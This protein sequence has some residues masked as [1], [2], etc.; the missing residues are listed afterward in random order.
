MLRV[1][2]ALRVMWQARRTSLYV[3]LCAA[4]LTGCGQDVTPPP[5]PELG[6]LFS[7]DEATRSE[8]QRALE[9]LEARATDVNAWVDLARL[10]DRHELYGAALATWEGAAAL[11]PGA[12]EWKVRAGAAAVRARDFGRAE[13]WLQAS[14]DAAPTERGAWRR[15][16]EL[17]LEQGDADGARR[18]FERVQALAPKAHD[19][20]AGLALAA[21]LAEDAPSALAHARAA[22]TLAPDDP[23]LRHVYGSALRLAGR[24]EEALPHLE[25]GLG[26]SP[27]WTDET[28]QGDGAV[29]E[30]ALVERADALAADAKLREAAELYRRVIELRPGDAKVRTRLALTLAQ[31]GQV[32]AGLAL[33]DEA[34]SASPRRYDLL[35]AR[36]DVLRIGGR[37]EAALRAA[38]DATRA[39][40]D[41][42]QAWLVRGVL[43]RD[44]GDLDAALACFQSALTAEADNM[45]ATAMA[46]DIHLR[47]HDYAAAATVLEGPLVDRARRP[48]LE[49]V[50]LLLQAQ[51]R[52]GR[53]EATLRES[54]QRARAIHGNAA[55]SLVTAGGSG[56]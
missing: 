46:A 5:L 47:K 1:P 50:Q 14:V 10:L 40:P 15:L 43:L 2:R 13:A 24:A 29:G 27:T 44:Q 6:P 25:V 48:P 34:L 51:K 21:L 54:L 49:Y 42:V 33:V 4:S 18:C 26:T 20:D 31:D 35:L 32:E 7:V 8:L 55:R 45:Q 19:G 52:A 39:W 23:Y 56:R 30:L 53:P 28:A 9:A 41:R 38:E 22:R 11:A 37:P 16:G 12:V 3:G 17:R 36:I